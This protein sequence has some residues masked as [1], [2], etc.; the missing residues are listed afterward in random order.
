MEITRDL[1]RTVFAVLFIAALTGLSFWI[2]RPFL[3]AT[4]WATMIAVSTWPLMEAVQ[5][6]LWNKRGLAVTVM[7]LVLLLVF[8]VPFALALAALASHADQIAER[9]RSLAIA[10]LPPPPE[11]LQKVPFVGGRVAAA[12]RDL[13][14]EGGEALLVQAKPHVGSV[15]RWFAA[16]VGNLG[17]LAVQF[18][19]TVILTA[20]LY[21][22]GETAAT[23]VRRFATR[24]AGAQGEAAVRLAG[25]AIRAVALGVVLTAILQSVLGGIGLVIAGVP[26]AAVLTAVMFIL[27]LAQIGPLLVLVPSVAWLY[28]TGAS[29]WGT[30]LLV[31]TV[32]TGPLDNLVRPVLIRKGADLP[33]LLVFAGVVGGLVAFG[34]VGIF[35]GPVLLAVAFTLTKAW[36][37]TQPGPALEGD[38]GPA[39][40]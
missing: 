15:V 16:Q 8:L 6:R 27:S 39:R 17:A 1:T 36:V 33:F 4:L 23:G 40:E 30:F 19:V 20:I 22:K 11:W 5:A 14:A 26:F 28:W 18:L 29:G 37:E 12:W 32:V 34:L 7:T 10:E 9:A 31:W 13:V 21:A 2:L 25:Q 3:P 38:A 35:I 24:L